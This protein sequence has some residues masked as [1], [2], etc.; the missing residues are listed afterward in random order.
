MLNRRL[1]DLIQWYQLKVSPSLAQRRVN[2]LYVPTCS[3]YAINCLKSKPAIVALPL[4]LFRLA[5][6]NPINALIKNKKSGGSH[7]AAS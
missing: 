7:A 5:C 2:C 3:Q 6:C 4:I 1:V